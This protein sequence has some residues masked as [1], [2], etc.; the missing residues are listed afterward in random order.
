MRAPAPQDGRLIIL[1]TEYRILRLRWPHG[2]PPPADGCRRCGHRESSHGL[3]MLH[4]RVRRDH[5][6]EFPTAEQWT[7]RLAARQAH[8]AESAVRSW[9]TPRRRSA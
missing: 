6:Y 2:S 1:G 8:Q 3:A 5:P 4:G 9:F 7:K